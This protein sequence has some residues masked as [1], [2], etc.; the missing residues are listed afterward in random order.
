MEEEKFWGRDMTGIDTT[1][2][3][4]A[5]KFIASIERDGIG[6]SVE[7]NRWMNAAS[8]RVDIWYKGKEY[9]YWDDFPKELQELIHKDGNWRENPDVIIDFEPA[10]TVEYDGFD[11]AEAYEH[12]VDD[13]SAFLG[14]SKEE[15]HQ[16]LSACMM[17]LM[18]KLAE[19]Q[20]CSYEGYRQTSIPKEWR[21]LKAGKDPVTEGMVEGAVAL[22]PFYSGKGK[23]PYKEDWSKDR[24]YLART[25]FSAKIIANL[26]RQGYHK[27]LHDLGK[28]EMMEA[29]KKAGNADELRAAVM[30][31]FES[32]L[33]D[34]VRPAE[35]SALTKGITKLLRNQNWKKTR[36]MLAGFVK[37]G[38][39]AKE[40]LIALGKS[41]AR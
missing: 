4:G 40:D 10:I 17:E 37:G 11:D 35:D 20:K 16:Y 38:K 36:K 22:V 5:S 18:K 25:E 19:Q 39:K 7:T 26:D 41:T 3:L 21:M 28:D 24:S 13:E 27:W 9:L 1:L 14:K 23:D 12:Q 8:D 2:M 29:I 6:I 34:D 30:S 15:I 32:Y 31:T 33:Q